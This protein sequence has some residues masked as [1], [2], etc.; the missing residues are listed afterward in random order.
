LSGGAHYLGHDR[1]NDE[2]LAVAAIA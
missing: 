2:Q 1:F